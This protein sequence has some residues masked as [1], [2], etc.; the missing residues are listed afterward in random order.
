M[1]ESKKEEVNDLLIEVSC[2]ILSAKSIDD[3][4]VLINKM[5]SMDGVDL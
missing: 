1:N 4:S 5:S 3:L 2:G